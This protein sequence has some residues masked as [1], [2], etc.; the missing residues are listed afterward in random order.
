[1]LELPRGTVAFLFTDIEGSTALWE[2]DRHAMA[3]AVDRQV[4]L[5]RQAIESH[6]GVLYKV[7]GDA[8]QAAFPTAPDA[9]S[10][11]LDGQRALLTE[12]WGQCGPIQVRMALHAGE[13][14]P[15]V[16]GDYMA[17]PLN[18][19]ARLLAAGHG[20]QIL[21]SQTVQQLARG[22]LP[23][24]TN[25]RDLGDHRLRDLLE[26]ERV[27]QLVH[28]DLPAD[29]PSLRS[30]EGYPNNLL[31]Q[32]T[33]LLGRE[34]ELAEIGNLLRRDDVHLVTLTGPG[35]VGKTRLALQAAADLLEVFPDGAFFVELAPL[36]DPALVPSTVASA[37]GVREE[38]GQPLLK[39]LTAF[40]CD[41]QLLLVL[42]NFEHLLPAATVVSDLLR[43]CS[44]LKVLV[45]SR[46]P[47]HLR[48]EREYPVPT[49]GVPDP[50]RR[51]PIAHVAQYEAVRLFVERARAA[52]P[53][54]ALTDDNAA[55]VAE[56][57]RR[58]DGLPLALELA[59][60]RI[61]LLP[62]QSL[63]ERLGERL[64]VLTGGARDA[65]ARPRTL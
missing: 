5:L 31:R 60:A 57:C 37:L 24:G 64:K 22:A 42:D 65:P 56:I 29:F 49:L 11:A 41:R 38:G 58:L 36:A 25:L 45:T 4:A 32:P 53:D 62:P 27:V 61:K 16:R 18:R 63:L 8:I 46:A 26:P 17:A 14:Q 44:G 59:A 3:T 12:D 1:M 39:T 43:A 15:D 20:G 40:L 55:A 13:A 30:L 35:G 47:L 48:G 10:A 33:P 6:H 54:F 52:R 23:A 28:P 21:L 2:R 19:L 34:R 7:V 50:S 51:E 9:V